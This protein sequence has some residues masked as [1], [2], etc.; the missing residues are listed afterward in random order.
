[1][2]TALLLG[3]RPEDT[4]RLLANLRRHAIEVGAHR[5]ARNATATIPAGTD[6]VVSMTDL[7]ALS[8]LLQIVQR[9]ARK[10]GIP[11]VRIP[12]RWSTASRVLARAGFPAVTLPP[13]TLPPVPKTVAQ[14][15]S[16]SPT[17]LEIAMSAATARKATTP[18]TTPTRL[19]AEAVADFTLRALAERVWL[20]NR[21]L[22]KLVGAEAHSCGFPSGPQSINN[23]ARDAREALG[24]LKVGRG[25]CGPDRAVT[26]DAPTY[27]AMCA[28]LGVT[29]QWSPSVMAATAV[30]WALWGTCSV[31]GAP[32]GGPCRFSVKRGELAG[33]ARGLP[34]H[35]R[36]PAGKSARKAPPK[37]TPTP[38]PA[39]APTRDTTRTVE[40]PDAIAD[41]VKALSELAW[42]V[43]ARHG[44]VAL[45]LTADSVDYEAEVRTTVTRS[46]RRGDS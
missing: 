34:H 6:V 3:S 36:K 21:D 35:D 43:M 20:T 40:T 39:P 13:R 10:A 14:P 24:I 9:D 37:P 8:G 2:P 25:V 12:H 30:D 38:V 26:V 16:T 22:I 41:A 18:T 29:P 4:A 23:P 15:V 5:T 42:D 7:N 46:L 31:C 1:M 28:S 27:H 19:T 32:R 44:I 45:S 33:K 11:V 17:A